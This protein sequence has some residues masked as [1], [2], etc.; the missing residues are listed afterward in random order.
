MKADVIKTLEKRAE[1]FDSIHHSYESREIWSAIDVI[2]RL[3][4]S[5]LFSIP[6]VVRQSEQCCEP[7]IKGLYLGTSCPKC[8]KPFRQNFK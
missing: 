8:N 1:H 6:V 3:M 7:I 4:P 5:E 2:E